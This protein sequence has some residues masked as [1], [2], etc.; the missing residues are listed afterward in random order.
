MDLILC[1]CNDCKCPRRKP[2]AGMLIEA[3]AR[4]GAAPADT[5][6]VGDQLDDLKAAFHAGCKRVLVR[7]G[8]GRQTLEEGFPKYVCP[9]S[10]HD[11]L[12]AAVDAELTA[13]P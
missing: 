13:A 8:L 5:P 1:C 6:F 12:A 2:A 4:D 10:V 7:S 3:L 11:D 9:V